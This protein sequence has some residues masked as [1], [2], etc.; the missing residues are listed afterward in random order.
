MFWTFILLVTLSV[1]YHAEDVT[2]VR[3]TCPVHQ[4]PHG[5]SCYEVVGAFFRDTF[6][7]AQAWCERRGGHLAFIPDEETQLF[8]QRHLDPD[9]DFWFGAASSAT[10]ASQDSTSEGERFKQVLKWDLFLWKIWKIRRVEYAKWKHVF[11]RVEGGYECSSSQRNVMFVRSNRSYGTHET[12][13]EV[14]H[15]WKRLEKVKGSGGE[16]SAVTEPSIIFSHLP[17][18]AIV[19]FHTCMQ[20]MEICKSKLSEMLMSQQHRCTKHNGQLIHSFQS[21]YQTK[22]LHLASDNGRGCLK[23]TE[24]PHLCLM[25]RRY[26]YFTAPRFSW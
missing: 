23:V 10:R 25:M 15:N 6:P 2:K 12:W 19:S 22:G 17:I 13:E 20:N 7:G 16:T 3:V 4:K 26:C 18:I 21:S 24:I 1:L 14:L 11:N 5:G 8:L 9:E